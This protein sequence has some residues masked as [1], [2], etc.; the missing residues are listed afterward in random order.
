MQSPRSKPTLFYETAGRFFVR[1][2]VFENWSLTLKEVRHTVRVFVNRMPKR[3]F[4]QKIE[5]II[6]T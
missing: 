1:H 4:K 6:R 2:S 3:I 5:E